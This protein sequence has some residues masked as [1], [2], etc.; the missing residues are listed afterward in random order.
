[1][2]NEK[3]ACTSLKNSR[4][5]LKRETALDVLNDPVNEENQRSLGS[6]GL[7]MLLAYKSDTVSS[8]Y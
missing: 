7:T 2:S 1:M 6:W 3:D 5:M 4:G 8:F